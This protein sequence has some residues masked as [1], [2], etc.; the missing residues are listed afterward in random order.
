MG[1]TWHY[2]R[3]DILLNICPWFSFFGWSTREKLLEIP[4][5]DIGDNSSVLNRVIVAHN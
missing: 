3:L 5:L 1:K 4:G 2:L